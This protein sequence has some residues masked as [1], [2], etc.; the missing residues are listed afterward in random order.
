MNTQD[1]ELFL[2]PKTK[3]YGSH[4]IMSNINKPT[5][6]KYIN[7]D[8]RFCEE[9]NSSKVASY[10][11]MIP[12]RMTNVKNITVLSAEIPITFYNI[13]EILGN[14]IFTVTDTNSNMVTTILIPD[15]QY[16][17]ST[18]QTQINT[19]LSSTELNLT[20]SINQIS[21]P[22]NVYNS[23]FTASSDYS[24]TIQFSIGDTNNNGELDKYNFKFKLGWLMGFRLPSYTVNPSTTINSEQLM[25]LN[26]S[27][28]LY[29]A[30]D[31]FKGI[32]NSFLTPMASSFINK[33][34][35]ARISMDFL[36]FGFGSILPANRMNG[37]LTSDLRNYNGKTDLQK[38][39]ISLLNELG[40]PVSLNGNN[41]SFC[42]KVD[43][44]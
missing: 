23:S 16:T 25:D 12:E 27:R 9:Y 33:S 5:K 10:N 29:L 43:Y 32:H 31:E 22:S 40:N 15:N 28:Y 8:T 35:L 39:N 20:F 6:S 41:F 24:Y 2:E 26:G 11:I 7:I 42:L 13:S 30:V 21:P 4:M 3:Q 17:A 14:N 34:I 18:L 37:L 38:L 44:E 36:I 19:L 1:N